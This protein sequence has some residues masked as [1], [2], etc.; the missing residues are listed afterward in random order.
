MRILNR[1]ATKASALTLTITLSACIGSETPLGG[2]GEQAMSYTEISQTF[3]PNSEVLAAVKPAPRGSRAARLKFIKYPMGE[4]DVWVR[5]FPFRDGIVVEAAPGSVT[6]IWVYGAIL[7][8]EDGAAF[9]FDGDLGAVSATDGKTSADLAP[10]RASLPVIQRVA[11]RTQIEKSLPFMKVRR[12]EDVL[13]I[14]RTL[15]ANGLKPS[16]AYQTQKRN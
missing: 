2:R 9:Y 14:Y 13:T 4:R 5:F 6:T 7:P 11:V 3:G 10:F 8:H 1:L 15:A 16:G 12:L